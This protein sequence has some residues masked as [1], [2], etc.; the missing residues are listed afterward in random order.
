MNDLFF[1]QDFISFKSM[2]RGSL[3]THMKRTQRTPS[4]EQ[5]F[6]CIWILIKMQYIQI[7][8]FLEYDTY[9]LYQCLYYTT[10]T[11][12]PSFV[13]TLSNG[14][15][16]TTYVSRL[17]IGTSL[18]SPANNGGGGM[19][20]SSTSSSVASC[21]LRPGMQFITHVT[22]IRNKKNMNTT[23]NMIKK[24]SITSCITSETSSPHILRP[25]A[26]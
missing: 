20:S 19:T 7:S 18:S 24:F 16:I 17:V 14:G 13:L 4:L 8:Q 5:Q 12:Q 2:Y 6:K 25:L 22:A 9:I 21:R 11:G 1:K 23:S 26:L 3:L 10:C 15:A